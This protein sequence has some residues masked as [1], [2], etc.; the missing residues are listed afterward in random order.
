MSN[1]LAKESSPYLL[2]HK[3]NPVEWLPWGPEAFER[4]GREDKPVFLSIGYSS[5]HWCHVMAHESFEDEE[6]ASLL[7][8]HFVSVKVDREERPDVDETYMMAVQL[9]SGRGGWPMSVFLTPDKAPFFAGTYFPKSDRGGYPGFVTILRQLEGLWRSERARVAE[10]AGQFAEAVTEALSQPTPPA[11]GPLEASLL[12]EAFEQVAKRFDPAHGGTVGAP[13][14]PPHGAL[15]L[16]LTAEKLGFLADPM[17]TEAASMAKRTLEQ[18]A[19]GGIHDH[20]GG[21]FHRYSTDE[22]WLLPHFE[23]ML[24]DNALMIGNLGRAGMRQ[25]AERLIGWLEREMRTDDGLYASALDADSEGEEGKYYVWTLGELMDALGHGADAFIA[26]FGLEEEGNFLDEATHQKTGANILHLEEAPT[27]D[28]TEELRLLL[29]KRTERI[30]P[31]RDDKAL[32]GWNGLLVAGLADAGA[33][34]QANAL[35]QALWLW[36][37]EG[38]PH[39]VTNG[40]ATGT[41]Y[42]EDVAGLAWGF[43]KL[44]ESVQDGPWRER[45]LEIVDFAEAFRDREAGGYFSTSDRHEK[46]LGRTKP[47]LDHPIPSA[48]ALM[49]RSLLRLGRQ[50][51]AV[52]LS[53]AGLGWVERAPGS[54]EALLLAAA[55]AL[56]AT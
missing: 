44:S 32:M 56:E 21:G 29:A 36:W 2:Q 52:R 4:A 33:L 19:L 39:Q 30:P 27:R 3:D 23:K 46:L 5:C 17:R 40:K 34:E 18:M 13:K 43:V 7:N 38:T 47:Y 6:V 37:R 26:D 10:A 24:Y 1:L 31:M 35:A 11:S 25:P 53:E 8:R 16:W 22:R 20:V 49:A 15:E 9:Q 42:L 55:E 54:S 50:E 12:L 51:E 45:A 28:W 41:A 14:F 48:N